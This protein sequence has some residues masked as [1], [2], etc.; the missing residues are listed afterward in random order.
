MG[1]EVASCPKSVTDQRRA[2]YTPVSS[3]LPPLFFQLSLPPDLPHRTQPQPPPHS[4]PGGQATSLA[5]LRPKSLSPQSPPP[6]GTREYKPRSCSS[7]TDPGSWASSLPHNKAPCPRAPRPS[8]PLKGS[9]SPHRGPF[10]LWR[11]GWGGGCLLTFT[12]RPG[13]CE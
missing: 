9:L 12:P 7:V 1:S 8:W 11:P 13:I 5:F 4:Y 10:E 3:H 6:L 2:P